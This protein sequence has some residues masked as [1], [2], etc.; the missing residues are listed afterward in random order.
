MTTIQ[1]IDIAISFIEKTKKVNRQKN[2]NPFCVNI[3]LGSFD[4]TGGSCKIEKELYYQI[5]DR[6]HKVSSTFITSDK[7]YYRY[8]NI[9][10]VVQKL[11]KNINKKYY[12]QKYPINTFINKNL[13]FTVYEKS[14]VTDS[15]FPIINEYN[16]IY[17]EKTK[18]YII[19]DTN[20]KNQKANRVYINFVDETN[21]NDK[22]L[23][24]CIEFP[25]TNLTFAKSV[26]K[27]ILVN[28]N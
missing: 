24:I 5:M 14:F 10:M 27:K 13:C 11:G 3:H 9:E 1:D 25:F 2:K 28:S 4:S 23:K 21:T 7:K 17:S 8:K 16:N 6:T 18:C 20:N 15:N 26:L 22:F 19:E 12:T